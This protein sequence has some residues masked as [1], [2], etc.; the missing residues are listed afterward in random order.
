MPGQS[1]SEN[2]L[3]QHVV[4]V[5]M[6]DDELAHLDRLIGD[7]SWTRPHF[8]RTLIK[9]GG[10]LREIDTGPLVAELGKV[11]SNLNQ[12][13]RHANRHDGELLSDNIQQALA[14]LDRVLRDISEAVQ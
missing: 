6:H 8:I 4:Q 9:L 14:M 1:G 5:R 7:S 2:R 12:L 13:A 10:E 3:R 11:G